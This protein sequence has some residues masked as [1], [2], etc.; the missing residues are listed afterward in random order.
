VLSGVRRLTPL[1]ARRR[2]LPKTLSPQLATLVSGLPAR[3]DSLYE[4]EFDGYRILSRFESGNPHLI[5]RRGNDWSS[6]MPGLIAELKTMGVSL[7]WLDGE[8]VVLDE[9]GVPDFN[10]LQNAF[11]REDSADITYF[12]FDVPFFEGYDLRNVELPYRRQLL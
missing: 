7:G 8:I 10:A 12:L 3:G 1:R 4:I 9:H 11:D 5:A 6:K 2:P